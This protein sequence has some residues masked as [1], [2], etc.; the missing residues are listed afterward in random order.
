MQ[1][2]FSHIGQRKALFQLYRVAISSSQSTI[3]WR[4]FQHVSCLS[5][6]VLANG[7]PTPLNEIGRTEMS[8]SLLRCACDADTEHRLDSPASLCMICR[9]CSS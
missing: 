2:G 9:G 8:A 6:L 3:A 7:N 1:G 5:V 4:I